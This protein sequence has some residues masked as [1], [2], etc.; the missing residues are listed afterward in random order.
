MK[1]RENIE[2]KLFDNM[3]K[4]NPNFIKKQLLN[5]AEEEKWI[6][7]AGMKKGA[8]HDRLGIP[9]DD[10]IPMSVIN[11]HIK[12]L[13][14]KSAGD[15]ELDADD[16]K[17]MKQLVAAKNMKK[18]NEVK[19]FS[20]EQKRKQYL[21]EGFGGVIYVVF[22]GTSH[23]IQ[24][25]E[26]YTAADGEV[27]AK[28]NDINMAQEKAEQLNGE[29]QD[30]IREIAPAQNDTYFETLSAA[31]DAVR[32]SV[33]KKGYEV[34]EDQMFNQFGTGGISY[35]ETK[36]ANIQLLKGGIPQRNRSVTIAIYRMD[37][38]RYELTTYIN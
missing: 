1:S 31:L 30:Q 35:G 13:E 3:K 14:K 38:G 20:L 6:Q 2:N 27:V 33:A 28:F 10:D 21:T 8:L 12:T 25:Q 24:P 7:K 15:K 17:F 22:D 5:E 16:A 4:L 23:W 26:D 9:E 34:D 19:S 11:R 36:R 32:Q 37:S 29:S 18:L